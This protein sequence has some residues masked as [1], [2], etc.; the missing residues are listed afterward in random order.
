MW[1]N[2]MNT[3]FAPPADSIVV[4]ASIGDYVEK[5]R[6][7]R[8]SASEVA[9]LL[10]DVVV[11]PEIVR[12]GLDILKTGEK[13][14]KVTDNDLVRRRADGAERL[15]FY[16]ISGMANWPSYV[17]RRALKDEIDVSDNPYGEASVDPSA[18]ALTIPPVDWDLLQA[19]VAEAN[20][21]FDTKLSD[22]IN[23][24]KEVMR[25]AAIRGRVRESVIYKYAAHPAVLKI[26]SD[27]LGMFPILNKINLLLSTND[28]LQENS[29]QFPHLDPI[30]FKIA[31][32]F[33]YVNDVDEDTGPFQI[34]RADAS[35]EIQLKYRYRFGR[36]TDEQ[37]FDVVGKEN[38]HVC[39]GP[40]GTANF[41]DTCRGF[42]FGS[43]PAPKQRKLIMYQYV[44]PF[45]AHWPIA[46]RDVATKFKGGFIAH[47]E[48]SGIPLSRS[49]EHLIGIH[50]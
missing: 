8:P 22:Q 32:I 30:D 38:L 24:G 2:R 19:V 42:H 21:C 20:D 48:A 43:R 39:V 6:G 17:A 47:A 31:K 1:G 12:G 40:K 36:L 3:H 49:E 7:E 35:D 37:M 45:A 29:S 28:R 44:T 16:L 4:H 27:Y 23:P 15:A 11:H 46:E 50:R 34:M 13:L 25:S 5:I 9:T 18:G 26:V 41:A 33:L 10:S 14:E